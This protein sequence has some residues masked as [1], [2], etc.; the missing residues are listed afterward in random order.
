MNKKFLTAIICLSMNS[1]AHAV[2]NI[3]EID[4][5]INYSHNRQTN[6]LNSTETFSYIILQLVKRF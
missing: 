2:I 5:Y 4:N 6:L 1:S 3:A